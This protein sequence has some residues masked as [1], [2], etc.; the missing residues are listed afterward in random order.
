MRKNVIGII[1][2]CL[3]LAASAAFVLILNRLNVLNAKFTAVIIGVIVLLFIFALVTQ[4]FKGGRIVGKVFSVL[5]T[6]VLVIGCVFMNK[7]YTTLTKVSSGSSTPVVQEAHMAFL[8]MKDSPVTGQQDLNGRAIGLIKSQD[9]DLSDQTIDELNGKLTTAAQ[10]VAYEN[11]QQLITALYDGSVD[12]I[13]LNEALRPLIIENIKPNFNEETRVLDT[14]RIENP[15]TRETGEKKDESSDADLAQKKTQQKSFTVYLS[16]NDAYGQ[17]SLDG[18][19]S[20]VNIIAAVNPSTHT[21]LLVTTP[22]DYY[23]PLCFGQGEGGT[24]EYRDKLTHAGVYGIDCSMATLENVYGVKLDYYARVNFT[25]F[26]NIVDVLGG[27]DV[28][29]QYAF[30]AGK[31]S[32]SEGVNHLDGDQALTFARERH[33]FADGDFQRG[34]NQMQ[35]IKAMADKI[36]SPAVLPNFMPLMDQV[37]DSFLTDMPAEA[38]TDLVKNQLSDNSKWTIQT[39]EVEG[40]PA[41]AY[42]Y[43]MGTDLSMVL[44]DAESVENTSAAIRN[45]LEGKSDG[46]Q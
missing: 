2:L 46:Q 32:F 45:V 44:P 6:L 36:L 28:D 30:T 15:V 8:V 16:G 37:S 26:K 33:A 5:V 40:T 25:G 4:F 38:I 3:Q 42:S 20:D 14:Y 35:V 18:G 24:D 13:V 7:T 10:E 31:Y 19:R 22:R 39:I 11:P 12:C 23:V 27:I 9:R 43:T 1:L 34:R 17:V 41:S 29:S 21:I